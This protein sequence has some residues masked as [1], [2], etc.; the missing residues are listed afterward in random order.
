MDGGEGM[1]PLIERVWSKRPDGL[2]KKPSLLVCY[3]LKAHVTVS[4]KRL[5]TKLKMH[6]AVIPGGSTSQLQP[7]HVSVNKPFKGFMHEEW[8]KRIEAQTHH[9]KPAGRVKQP[10]ISNVCEWVKNSWQRVKS[11][12]TVKSFKKCGIINA[13]D[14]SEDDILYEESDASCENN[15]EDD[16]SGS[17]DFLGF[18]DK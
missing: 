10:P 18:Y 13:L 11:G 3:Q 6:L 17:D 14:G 2:L 12:T 16:F 15:H 7:L 9:V 1:K 5:A 8:A 4:T